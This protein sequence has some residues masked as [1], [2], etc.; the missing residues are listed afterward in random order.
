LCAA[1][2]LTRWPDDGSIGRVAH[3]RFHLGCTALGATLILAACAPASRGDTDPLLTVNGTPILAGDFRSSVRH[4][5]RAVASPDV[6]P[7]PEKLALLAWQ[8]LNKLLSDEVLVQHARALGLQVAPV[9]LEQRLQEAKQAGGGDDSF[10]EFLATSG[11]D[12]WRVRVNFE[13]NLLLLRLRER[14]IAEAAVSEEEIA[15]EHR[16]RALEFTEPASVAL[17]VIRFEPSE[18]AEDPAARAR[19]VREAIRGGLAFEEAARRFSD[20]T[21]TRDEGGRMGKVGRGDL[22]PEL[23]A[24][25]FALAPGEISEPVRVGADAVLLK[26]LEREEG[27]LK[28]LAEVHDQVARELRA[29]KAEARLDEITRRL[30]REATLE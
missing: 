18:G 6:L 11:L 13:R 12:E 29:R 9:E 27:R 22:L 19:S 8:V 24:A 14:L 23:E 4:A 16:A 7:F 26:V 2:E 28:P 3:P 15:A 21:L 10:Q 17:A 5:A 25:A 20:E 1:A 30:L